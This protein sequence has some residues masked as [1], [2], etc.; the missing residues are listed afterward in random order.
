MP[1]L[2]LFILEDKWIEQVNLEKMVNEIAKEQGIT[3]ST[4]KSYSKVNELAGSLPSPSVDNVFLLDLEIDGDKEAGLKLSQTIRKHDL[5]AT[6]IFITVHDEFLPVTYKYQSEALDFIAK[7]KDDV[8]E[9]LVRAFKTIHSKLRR[10]AR[11]TI[12][13]KIGTGYT[14]I[15]LED[16]L[17]FTPNPQNSHQSF[18]QLANNQRITVHGSLTTLEK[19]S[20]MLFRSHR[21]CLINIS[22]FTEINT[23][24]HTVLLKGVSKPCPLSR[25]KNTKLLNQLAEVADTKIN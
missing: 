3:I 16:I 15:S 12:L 21:R 6:I 9:H 22:K 7:D 25:L 14:R 11:P 8:K 10:F 24:N 18:L 5:Y 23:H 1:N 13:L 2:N 4:L 17:Y 19:E 20:P